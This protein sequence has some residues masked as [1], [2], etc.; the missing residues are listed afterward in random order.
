MS[1][2]AARRCTS[3][4]VAR[5]TFGG[6][7]APPIRRCSVAAAAGTR[8]YCMNSAT[9]VTGQCHPR[10][11]PVPP[12]PQASA[13]GMCRPALVPHAHAASYCSLGVQRPAVRCS[14][15]VW[16][17]TM[18]CQARKAGPTKYSSSSARLSPSS[19]YICAANAV[20]SRTKMAM[21]LKPRPLSSAAFSLSDLFPDVLLPG[22]PACVSSALETQAEWATTVGNGV[23]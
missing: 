6:F 23:H 11:G 15:A 16:C 5:P 21:W 18:R 3:Q 20:H 10:R 4:A 1:A 7:P 13:G 17:G 14:S 2:H 8:D 19:M 9:P 12:P 22:D